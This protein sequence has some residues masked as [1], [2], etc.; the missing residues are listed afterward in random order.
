MWNMNVDQR[1]LDYQARKEYKIL[2]YN[3]KGCVMNQLIW[4]YIFQLQVYNSPTCY[5][6]V[7]CKTHP[8]RCIEF[9]FYPNPICQAVQVTWLADYYDMF[10]KI[11]RKVF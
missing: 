2:K 8:S 11:L 3:G 7:S 10:F 9:F 5:N 4:V 1:F 6:E